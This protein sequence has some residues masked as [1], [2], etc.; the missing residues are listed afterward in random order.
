[1]KRNIPFACTALLWFSGI[2]FAQQPDSSK[3]LLYADF[4]KIENGRPV[5]AR[6]GLIQMYGYEES[7]V[8]KSAFKGQEGLDPPGPELVRVKADDPN[9]LG[10]F[11]YTLLAPNQWAGVTLEIHGLPDAD[12]KPVPED[13]TGYKTLSL[14]VYATGV[15]ILR[16]EAIS[17]ER[18][19]D[20]SITYPQHQFLVRQ[21]LNTYKVPL[22]GF[23]QPA[24]VTERRMDPKDI[25]RRLTSIN[26]TAF[27]DQCERLEQGMVIVDNVMFEK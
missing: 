27:C 22:T 23:T 7:K 24:W 8:H 11:D 21:G 18:G 15:R 5:S 26:L 3:A 20:M 10:K 19:K 9:R 16:L 6:G 25:F 14:Q 1:M 12:G 2:A 13:V 17:Q 4:E